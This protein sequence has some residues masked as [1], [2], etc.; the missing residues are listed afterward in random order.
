MMNRKSYKVSVIIPAYN[1]ERW[2][3]QCVE[4]IL[5]QTY[6][7][8]ELILVND[9]STDGS[10]AVC[11]S[12][13]D[14]RVRVFSQPNRG[15]SAARNRGLEEA[16]GE[17]VVFVDS[18]DWLEPQALEVLMSHDVKADI[19]FF[20][21]L[22]RSEDSVARAYIP[23]ERFYGSAMEVQQGLV[24]LLF[25]PRHPDYVGFTW[26]KMFR[27]DIIREHGI[28]FIEGLTIREDEAFTYSYVSHCRTMATLPALL[29]NYRVQQTG[30]TF[31][32]KTAGEYIMLGEAYEAAMGWVDHSPLLDYL[33]RRG[34]QFY[35]F[36]MRR[37]KDSV[38][39]DK[40]LALFWSLWKSARPSMRFH[41]LYKLV[42]RLDSERMLRALFWLRLMFK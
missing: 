12:Y 42:M 17:Y 32:R 19:T 41:G 14:S 6:G 8:F 3:P 28:R 21:S 39:M 34:C 38:T 10:E 2:L 27:H 9:G 5:C 15:V 36:A 13:T 25:N 33:A 16:R 26:N 20:G 18:D 40:A 1:C 35:F 11:R 7:D 22:F 4:S 29:Y 24:N 37:S 30:L 23:E 31:S